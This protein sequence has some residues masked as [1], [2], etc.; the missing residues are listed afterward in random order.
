[1]E[2]GSRTIWLRLQPDL[3]GPPGNLF[4]DDSGTVVLVDRWDVAVVLDATTGEAKA[5]M[6]L[7]IL[8][9]DVGDRP[10]STDCG[11]DFG[12]DFG[13]EGAYRLFVHDRE[14]NYWVMHTTLG[15]TLVVDMESGALVHDVDP[16]LGAAIRSSVAAAAFDDVR[17]ASRCLAAGLGLPPDLVEGIE[18]AIRVATRTVGT[19]VIPELRTVE[20]WSPRGFEPA[21]ECSRRHAVPRMPPPS[22]PCVQ[23][24]RL[25]H[26]AKEAIRKL[27]A[28]PSSLPCY[29]FYRVTGPNRFAV[30]DVTRPDDM[31]RRVPSV[32][33]GMDREEVLRL[34]GAPDFAGGAFYGWDYVIDD[35]VV[36]YVLRILF[37]GRPVVDGIEI[38]A[39]P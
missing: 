7:M 11:V 28:R 10:S 27:G 8:V 20:E 29:V 18:K 30:L 19:E 6:N 4:V 34:L 23:F 35:A 1:M 3:E 36:P 17:R 24:N 16:Q 32:K 15:Q 38:V 22:W 37:H 21:I 25:R 14:R 2:G 13:W 33:K 26:T 12:S 39:I 9:D 31:A 5:A